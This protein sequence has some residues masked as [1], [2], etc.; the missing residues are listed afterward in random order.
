MQ[1]LILGTSCILADTTNHYSNHA[2]EFELYLMFYNHQGLSYLFF[3]ILF[4]LLVPFVP[5]TY[6]CWF[7]G[8]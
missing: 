8:S 6:V 1:Y 3:H 2:I 5:G 7:T 4:L